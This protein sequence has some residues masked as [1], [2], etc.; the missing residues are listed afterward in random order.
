MPI[1]SA[2]ASPT[3]TQ[4][5]THVPSLMSRI[6]LL[7]GNCLNFKTKIVL[8]DQ[9]ISVKLYQSLKAQRC[10]PALDSLCMVR[11]HYRGLLLRDGV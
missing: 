7:T 1:G 9:A 4:A 2:S 6:E 10:D 11:V 3:C 5:H 8:T